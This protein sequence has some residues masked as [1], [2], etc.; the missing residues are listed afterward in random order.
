MRHIEGIISSTCS[1]QAY[2]LDS[3]CGRTE[4]LRASPDQT[5]VKGFAVKKSVLSVSEVFDS[6]LNMLAV[7]P[8]ATLASAGF[9]SKDVGVFH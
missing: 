6:I 1:C 8:A 5:A 9:G 7:I 2:V 4:F 3:V